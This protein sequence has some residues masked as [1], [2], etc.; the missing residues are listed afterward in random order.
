M[1]GVSHSDGRPADVRGCRPPLRAPLLAFVLLLL[2]VVP[3]QAAHRTDSMQSSLLSDLNQIRRAHHLAPL[4]LSP[5]LTAAA[6][7]HA[8][9]MLARGY[10]S[11][12]SFDGTAYWRR[13]EAFYPL[14]P[15]D[16]WAT[17]ENLLWSP[18]DVDA[19]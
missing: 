1:H 13:I 18:G 19:R 3:A 7:A 10:F 8:D 2:V 4:T 16:T 6:G 11:H 9:E 17:G 15:G 5:E 12:S 14:I